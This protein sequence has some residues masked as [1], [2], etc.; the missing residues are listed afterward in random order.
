MTVDEVGDEADP[1]GE[2]PAHAERDD[3]AEPVGDP[4]RAAGPG[5][6][7]AAEGEADGAGSGPPNDRD[8][9]EALQEDIDEV[10]RRVDEPAND[11][12]DAVTNEGADDDDQPVDDTITPPG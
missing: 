8:R 2:N 5:D 7:D 4:A 6:E 1:D 3:E 11:S 9:L 12:G 10:R